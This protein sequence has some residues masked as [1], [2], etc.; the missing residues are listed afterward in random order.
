MVAGKE[1]TGKTT[2]CLSIVANTARLGMRS[3][4]FSQEMTKD[5]IIRKFLSMET[6]IHEQRLKMRNDISAPEW[7]LVVEALGR[8]DRWPIHIVDDM[9]GLTPL[10]FKRRY[11]K[12]ELQGRIELAFIDGL[13]LMEDDHADSGSN[14]YTKFNPIMQALAMDAKL[15]RK[16]ILIAHQYNRDSGKR[17]NKR[18]MLSDILGGGTRDAYLTLGL[19]RD[20]N[21]PDVTDTE[22]ITLKHRGSEA[23]GSVIKVGFLPKSSRYVDL[24]GGR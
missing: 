4:I 18:P 11:R 7:Q 23:A 21:Y 6:G 10:Q 17:D 2:F 15:E 19:Y 20:P 3:V 14:P 1:G 5:E 16:R 24:G 12:L 8:I 9:P 22:V 13:W